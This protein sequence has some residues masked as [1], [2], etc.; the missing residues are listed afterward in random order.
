MRVRSIAS[1]AG[2]GFAAVLVLA[3][4]A[5]ASD[6]ARIADL[7]TAAIV[8]TG[9]MEATYEVATADGDDLTVTGFKVALADG[10]GSLTLPILVIGGAGERE[11]GGFTAARITFDGGSATLGDDTVRWATAAIE[12]AVV[13]SV[14]EVRLRARIRPFGQASFG[15]LEIAR[16]GDAAPV[17]V[18]ALGI[19]VGDMT[20]GVARDVRVRA[21]GA[22]VPASFFTGTIVS[23]IIDRLDYRT[24]TA[25]I[26]TDGDYDTAG[27]TLSLRKL[28][29]DAVGVGRIDMD[30]KFSGLSLLG[31]ID[32]EKSAEARASAR[33]DSMTLR[34]ENAGLVERV[35]DMQAEMLGG[36]RDDVRFQFVYGAL[37]FALSFVDNERFRDQFLVAATAFLEDPRA[38]TFRVA[39]QEPVPLRQIYRAARSSP[40]ALPD[41]L[42][43]DVEANAERPGP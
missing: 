14:D 32:R 1:V 12:D 26:A 17:R 10:R 3:P 8:A 20:D 37:P 6:A 31:M 2:P 34:L 11:G 5:A 42:T 22:E 30:G 38:L 39:P 43:P 25:D 24:F 23:A 41:L 9:E 27:D 35:L 19:A 7:L 40:L 29:V 4:A 15:A 28:V 18:A 33:L 16:A 13:P 21:S 36:T